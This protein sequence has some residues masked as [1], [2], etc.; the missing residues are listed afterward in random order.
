MCLSIKVPFSLVQSYSECMIYGYQ[1]CAYLRIMEILE[2]IGKRCYD[3]RISFVETP[4]LSLRPFLYLPS[5][6]DMSDKKLD[7]RQC[8]M[9]LVSIVIENCLRKKE[10]MPLIPVVFCL[11]SSSREKDVPIEQ[12]VDQSLGSPKRGLITHA[13]LRRAYKLLTEMPEDIRAIAKATFLFGHVIF[14]HHSITDVIVAPAPWEGLQ[15][16][17]WRVAW[18][19]KKAKVKK[20]APPK[21]EELLWRQWF[22]PG[23]RWKRWLITDDPDLKRFTSKVLWLIRQCEETQST[24][25]NL[26]NCNLTELPS[27]LWRQKQLKILCLGNNKLQE[28]PPAIRQLAN[29]EKLSVYNN[30]LKGLPDELCDLENLKELIAHLNKLEKVPDKITKLKALRKAQ[31]SYNRLS[32]LP[33]GLFQMPGLSLDV[34]DNPL[35]P[36]FVA[37]IKGKN[38]FPVF[39]I[40]PSLVTN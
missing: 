28:L 17:R 16:E 7:M 12:I 33:E 9:A 2:K 37:S 25:L 27:A 39:V 8:K 26:S 35:S 19:A 21:A 22:D 3:Y 4:S 30:R 11:T 32:E 18:E 13:E 1:H 40:P 15:A 5:W 29:L 38:N 20:D 31:L 24:E 10:G 34:S 23:A 14:T 36:A 6:P